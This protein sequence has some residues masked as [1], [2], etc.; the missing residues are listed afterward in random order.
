MHHSLHAGIHF[1]R[2]PLRLARNFR[3]RLVRYRVIGARAGPLR[4]EYGC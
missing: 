1:A 2:E 3:V 4:Y